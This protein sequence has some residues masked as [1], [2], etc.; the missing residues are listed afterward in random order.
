MYPDL[1]SSPCRTSPHI[2]T[3]PSTCVDSFPPSTG[4]AILSPVSEDSHSS[5][6][7]KTRDGFV[8]ASNG[9]REAYGCVDAAG[10]AVGDDADAVAGLHARPDPLEV[11]GVGHDAQV[12]HVRVGDV[13]R[14]QH[15][16][17]AQLLAA[18]DSCVVQRSFL[19]FVWFFVLFFCFCFFFNMEPTNKTRRWISIRF[20]LGIESFFN[21]TSFF[22]FKGRK[23]LSALGFRKPRRLIS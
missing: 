17:H 15:R 18:S 1:P 4:F 16:L 8:H 5:G 23:T 21:Q 2:P 6:Q 9:C 13:G 22:V 11:G 10:L 19:F 12:F 7:P 3:P 20:S 14:P